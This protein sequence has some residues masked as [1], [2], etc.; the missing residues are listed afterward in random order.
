MTKEDKSKYFNFDNR[1]SRTFQRK[2]VVSIFLHTV[3]RRDVF[4]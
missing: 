4:R 1:V 3:M 2:N